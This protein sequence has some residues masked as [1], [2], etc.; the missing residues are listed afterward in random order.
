M[1]IWRMRTACWIPK[2]TDTHSEYVIFNAFPLQ[3]WLHENTS[4]PVLLILILNVL[5]AR[6]ELNIRLF[7]HSE[8][9]R[10]TSG[11]DPQKGLDTKKDG[12]TDDQT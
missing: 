2:A 5:T 1:T 10:L 7:R 8:T 3:Q 11:H 9:F 6:Y 12:L 4:M